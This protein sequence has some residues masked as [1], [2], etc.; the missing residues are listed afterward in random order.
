MSADRHIR[1]RF[2][3]DTSAHQVSVLHDDGLYR[4]LR[5]QQP[6]SWVYGFEVVTWPGYL[7][8]VGDMGSYV[9]SRIPDMFD[10]F[11]SDGINPSYWAEKLQAAGQDGVSEFAPERYKEWVE[12]W[13][14][15]VLDELDDDQ[16]EEFCA[17]VDDDM[18][19]Y[20]DSFD[21]RE[22]YMR[23]TDFDSCGIQISDA[24][25]LNFRRFTH[26]FIWALYAIVWTIGQYRS[27]CDSNQEAVARS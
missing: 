11:G 24:S 26:H 5:C 19:D 12:E 22:V 6:G 23:L 18:L 14:E 16:H 25:E 4:R 15:E 7:A 9:F 20:Y 27:L 8:Y 21:E 3:A 10:F 1:E 13:R 2:D 17:A